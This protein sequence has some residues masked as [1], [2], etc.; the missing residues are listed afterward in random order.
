MENREPG[1]GPGTEP[2]RFVYILQT[3]YE[4]EGGTNAA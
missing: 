1:D 4:P 2:L 3:P